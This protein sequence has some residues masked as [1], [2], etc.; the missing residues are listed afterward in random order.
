MVSAS[1]RVPLP[2]SL[3]LVLAQLLVRP[4]QVGSQLRSRHSSTGRHFNG[5]GHLWRPS[6][7]PSSAGGKSRRREANR[8]RQ[9]AFRAEHLNGPFHCCLWSHDNFFFWTPSG[10]IHAPKLCC[11]R[12][13][14]SELTW[15]HYSS[16]SFSRRR[17]VSEKPPF[18]VVFLFSALAEFL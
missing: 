17:L 15:K 5:G 11:N 4:E 1:R 16:A 13:S 10:T 18:G 7:Y 14:L 12:L 3:A 2:H 9:S 8:F 6:A